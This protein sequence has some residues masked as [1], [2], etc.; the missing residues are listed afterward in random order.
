MDASRV[1]TQENA[2][3]IRS[4]EALQAEGCPLTRAI[5]Q[6]AVEQKRPY[7]TVSAAWYRALARAPE[8]PS[9]ALRRLADAA[10]RIAA[11]LEARNE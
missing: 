7:A 5:R 11:A 1:R 3:A 6:V 8:R 9:E 2:D 4:I 10:E